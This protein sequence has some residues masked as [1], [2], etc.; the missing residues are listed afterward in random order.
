MS[1]QCAINQ[2]SETFQRRRIAWLIVFSL[3]F[4]FWFLSRYPDLLAEY[5]RAAGDSLL[6][7]DVGVLSK[8]AMLATHN[9]TTFWDRWLTT[10]I[11]WLDTN[12]IG[13]SFGFLF[14]AA[15]LLLLEQSVFIRKRGSQQGF[16][17]VT[18][19]LLLGMPL[20][21]C[22]N[23]ATPVALGLKKSGV[24]ADA[25]FA[26]LIA[27]PSLNPVGLVIVFL[28]FPW[29]MGVL[30]VGVILLF[31]YLFL[32]VL[33]KYFYKAKPSLFEVSEPDFYAAPS[34]Q[35]SQSFWYC[36]KRY[37][38]YLW[39]IVA[40]VLPL[41][42]L[43]G[44]LAALL[45]AWFPLQ[46]FLLASNYPI[47]T[48]MLAGVMGALLPMPM[49]VDIVL[50]YLFWQMGLS[51]SL[52]TTLLL[53]MAPT[54]MFAMYVMG[55]N[56][57]WRLSI[58]VTSTIALLGMGGGLAVYFYNAHY[59]QQNQWQAGAPMFKVS[60][61]FKSQQPIDHTSFT[62][63]FGS[64]VST[65]D[66]DN[67]GLD[68]LFI[69][70]SGGG[71]LLKNIG[72][73]RFK[74]VTKASGIKPHLDSIAGIWGDY[75]NDGLLDLLMINYRD[76]D[77][78][79]QS[80]LLYKNLGGGRFQDVTAEMGLN[81][82]DFSSAAAWGDY[83][84]DG[85]L[86]L[87]IANYGFLKLSGKALHGQSQQDKLYRNDGD[88]FVEVSQ[89]A[90]V[91]GHSYKTEEILDIEQAKIAGNRGFSFQ[92]VWFDFNNDHKLDLFVAQDFGTSQLYQNLGNGQ[93]KNVTKAMGLDVYGTSMGVEVL[94][95][96]QDGFWDLLVTTGGNNQLWLNQQ[97]HAFKDV[98]KKQQVGDDSRFGWGVVAFDYNNSG[99]NALYVVNG[100]TLR[101]ANLSSFQTLMAKVSSENRF[102]I[103]SKKGG[104][105]N[106]D[107]RLGVY[108]LA[109]SRGA[110][111]SDLNQDGL[112]DIVL[113]NRDD[114]QMVV[115]YQNDMPKQNYLKVKLVGEKGINQQAVGAR[116]SLYIKDKVQHKLL[117]AGHSFLSQSSN[118]LHFGLGKAKQVEKLVIEWPNGKKTIK[119]QLPVNQELVVKYRVL[120]SGAQSSTY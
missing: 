41:M 110:A 29:P 12:K 68:D 45:I 18:S 118:I 81:A 8:D 51:A 100:P 119:K 65:V 30:R 111:V 113:S 79:P 25:S 72:N 39:F 87:F 77:G 33:S 99:N 2:P 62:S 22:T 20:G 70:S 112:M 108:N 11:D 4:I 26:T 101:G 17:G 95:L 35:W 83:D 80:N 56:V 63:F 44:G 42:I 97:G 102:F 36:L 28:L 92:P 116:V 89:Q 15:I 32:P 40:R 13:M 73:M 1:S 14:A 105:I 34:E 47:L 106:L 61:V 43:M 109:T 120:S 84:N 69:G 71:R 52:A 90:G 75:N 58:A 48:I 16:W 103:P 23:C 82:N 60:Q 3:L 64:G 88:R 74:D 24:S 85:D 46:N 66:F 104:F 114:Q 55:R 50:V 91:A 78:S 49:F 98:A 21:V 67:D 7:R 86:D 37:R 27:S 94:D 54:S 59:G 6:K 93:F 53:T 31:L 96:N 115:I 9:V 38:Q 107:R 57:N 19:G 117:L 10:T 76:K 5:T